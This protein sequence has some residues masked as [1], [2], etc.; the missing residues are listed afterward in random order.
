MYPLATLTSV[1]K[2]VFLRPAIASWKRWTKFNLKGLCVPKNPYKAKK[3][4]QYPYNYFRKNPYWLS[5]LKSRRSSSQ[6]INDILFNPTNQEYGREVTKM[7]HLNVFQWGKRAGW[8]SIRSVHLALPKAEP[9]KQTAHRGSNKKK[10]DLFRYVIRQ[11]LSFNLTGILKEV[12]FQM[13]NSPQENKRSA[14][15]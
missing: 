10:R 15:P 3:N 11:F 7:T 14:E 2:I 12:L 6:S 5:T 1:S 9:T 13:F 4:L 8:K